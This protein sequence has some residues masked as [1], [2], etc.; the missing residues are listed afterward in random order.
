LVQIAIKGQVYAANVLGVENPRVALLSNGEEEEKGSRSVRDAGT[1]LQDLPMNFIGNVEPKEILAAQA[2]VV[3]ADGFTGNILVKTFEAS[4]S[5]LVRLIRD[6]LRKNVFSTLGGLLI[7]PAMNRLRGKFDTSTVGG[8]PLLGV[9]GVVI[10]G[11]GRS[12]AVAV[13]NAIYQARI[14]AESH[15]IEAIHQGV[16]QMQIPNGGI[17]L[18][19][20]GIS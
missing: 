20:G 14:A 18:E 11:H 13:K 9:N 7:R 16:Q 5:Y 12:N 3:V 15:V 8:A 10:I 19:T 6:E 1:M 4:T 17:A 2:N